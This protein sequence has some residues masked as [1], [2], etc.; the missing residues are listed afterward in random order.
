MRRVLTP[1][2]RVA[3]S[4]WRPLEYQPAFDVLADAFDRHIGEDTGT[5]MRSPFPAWELDDLRAIARD[6][7]FDDIS[8]TIGVDSVRYPSIEEFVRRE[9]ASSPFAE[10]VAEIDRELR[11]DLVRSV[12]DPLMPYVDDHGIIA[13][14]ESYL[15]T[16]VA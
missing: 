13:P 2:G 11:E 3:M 9:A 4:I 16:S 6:G 10:R 7:G 1:G 12:E 14:M 15:V 5:M 8:V